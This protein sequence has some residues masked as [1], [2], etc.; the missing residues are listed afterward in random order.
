MNAQLVNWPPWSVLNASDC[1]L[2]GASS[3]APAQEPASRVL[4]SY[5]VP[6]GPAHDRHQETFA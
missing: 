5:H 3:S 2:P 1:P 6:A 4:D